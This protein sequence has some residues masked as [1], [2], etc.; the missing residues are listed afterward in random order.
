M[1]KFLLT[2]RP[3]PSYRAFL[4]LVLS[5]VFVT[6]ST[7]ARAD[8]Q[9]PVDI[10]FA[11][12][13]QFDYPYVKIDKQ[14]YRLSVGSRIYSDQNL[15]T[16]PTAVPATA[17]VVYRTDFNGEISQLWLLTPDEAQ[18]MA[19]NPPQAPSR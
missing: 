8:R 12:A 3:F 9:F 17:A 4:A 11:K 1:P 5:A 18:A 15:I 16:M 13:A 7:A 14:V 2:A 10:A 6:V 19:A